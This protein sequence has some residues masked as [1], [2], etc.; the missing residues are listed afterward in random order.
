MSFDPTCWHNFSKSSCMFPRGSQICCNLGKKCNGLQL[1]LNCCAFSQL[2]VLLKIVIIIP[3]TSILAEIALVSVFTF[4]PIFFFQ[5]FLRCFVS[6]LDWEA[7]HWW[8]SGASHPNARPAAPGDM[9]ICHEAIQAV[10][11]C[12]HF[13]GPLKSKTLKEE[14]LPDFVCL[15]SMMSFLFVTPTG[16][17]NNL[18]NII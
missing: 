16:H 9:G 2:I 6:W 3:K 10:G 4:Y 14:T 1:C 12:R 11:Q 18:C 13:N 17:S 8:P 7:I 15:L 5:P